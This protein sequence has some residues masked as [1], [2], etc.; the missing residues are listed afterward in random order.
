MPNASVGQNVE[1]SVEGTILTVK[2]DLSKDFGASASGKTISIASSKGNVGVPGNEGI[3]IGVN[4]Y[5]YPES[6]KA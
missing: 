1:L 5:K 4:V 2:I 6:K 3:K